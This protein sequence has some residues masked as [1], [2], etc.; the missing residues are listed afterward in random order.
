MNYLELINYYWTLR[1]QGILSANEGDYYLFLIHKCNRL[2]WKNPFNLSNQL[3]CGYLGIQV[4]SLIKYRNKLKQVGLIDFKPGTKGV[5]TEYKIH[6]PKG[7]KNYTESGSESGTQTG[8]ES[9]TDSGKKKPHNIK[10]KKETKQNKLSNAPSAPAETDKNEFIKKIFGESFITI[11]ERWKDYKIKH[12]KFKYK[13]EDSEQSSFTELVNLSGKNYDKA[14]AIIQQSI[15]NGWKGFFELKEEVKKEDSTP[16]VNQP[17]K[18]KLSKMQI[19]INYLFERFLEDESHVT[20]ISTEPLHYDLLKKMEMIDFTRET[21]L[22]ISTKAKTELN[23][24]ADANLLL[25]MKKRFGV[26][27]FFKQQKAKGSETIFRMDG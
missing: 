19:E 10:P 1:E 20:I 5:N 14:A 3:C 4:K 26:I 18:P 23:G 27:E 15:A 24:N 8:S 7:C 2:S 22:E 25:A 6:F 9:G 11:W 13:S 16:P 12:F 21:F 17:T